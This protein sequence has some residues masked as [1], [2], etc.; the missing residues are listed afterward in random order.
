MSSA[1]LP[2]FLYHL[3]QKKLEVC[4]KFENVYGIYQNES[5][6]YGVIGGSIEAPN[7]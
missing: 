3:K 2:Q 4:S 1:V 7:V 6:E 5:K